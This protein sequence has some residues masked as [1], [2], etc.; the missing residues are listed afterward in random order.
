ML[1]GVR[2]RMPRIP[3]G[4]RLSSSPR[5]WHRDVINQPDRWLAAEGKLQLKNPVVRRRPGAATNSIKRRLG[6]LF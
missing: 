2:L 3:S 6:L 5:H 1:I 4:G